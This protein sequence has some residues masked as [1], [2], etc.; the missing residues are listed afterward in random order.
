M[1]I[2]FVDSI[3]R[4]ISRQRPLRF[5]QIQL[6]ISYVSSVLKR[7]GHSTELPVLSSESAKPSLAQAALVMV[8]RTPDVV[9]FTWVSTQYPFIDSVARE[10]RR[11]RP[12]AYLVIGGPHAS[13]NPQEPAASVYDAVCIGE[14]EDATDELV[15][16]LASGER[17]SG[18]RNMWLRQ[19]TG[20]M[21]KNPARPFRQDLDTLPLPDREMWL[22]WI[23]EESLDLPSVLLGRG[24]PYSCT[25]C[26]N[27]AVRRLA[28]GA[29][30]RFRSP[31]SIID[32]IDEVRRALA[33]STL[34][35]R[36]GASACGE[37]C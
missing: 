31:A 8:E 17:P 7:R 14:G 10:I 37:T 29:Y 34:G 15:A 23:D 6:G 22:P 5:C 24:C 35:S 11:V 4:G 13:L 1:Y 30:V 9:A 21:E 32:E 33:G 2:F 12:E 20:S 16:Q 27:H 36:P 26:S 3:E 18:I 25:Y 28:S 19:A